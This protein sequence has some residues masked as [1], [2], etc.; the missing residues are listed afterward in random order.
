MA[1]ASSSSSKIDAT[2]AA[3]RV[4]DDKSSP[5]SSP[6]VVPSYE[7]ALDALLGSDGGGG[8]GGLHQSTT[9]E[10]IRAA[11]ARRTHTVRDMRTYM[12]RC[13]LLRTPKSGERDDATTTPHF[14][15]TKVIHVTGT[16]GKGSVACLCERILRQ[17]HGV[18]TGL[19]TS[20]HLIDV[21]E[22]IR[23]NG[24]PVSEHVFADAYWR[25]RTMLERH[26][27]G[28][29]AATGADGAVVEEDDAAPLPVLPGYFRMLTLMAFYIFQNYEF[30][31]DDDYKKTS[32][33][34]GTKQKQ[35]IDVIILEV[36]MGGRFD[37]TNSYCTVGEDRCDADEPQ[38]RQQQQ[39]VACGIT[40]IDYDHCRVLGDT[41]SE[42]AWEKGGIYQV[43]KGAMRPQTPHPRRNA[44]EFAAAV[45]HLDNDDDDSNDNKIDDRVSVGTPCHRSQW[46]YFALDTNDAAVWPVF[47]LCAKLEGENRS[48]V[49]FVGT[50]NARIPTHC[51]IGLQGSH[52]RSNAE[53]AWALCEAV[54]GSEHRVSEESVYQA[55]AEASWPGR[56]QTIAWQDNADDGTPAVNLRLDG[57]HTLQSV[58]AGL[59]WY[60]QVAAAP[61][62]PAE[63]G[64]CRVL[65]FNCS[66]ER[67]PVELLQ[68]LVR[69]KFHAVYFCKADSARPS[70]VAMARAHELLAK[71]GIAALPEKENSE[72][73]SWL[74]TLSIIWRNLDNSSDCLHETVCIENAKI[75][76]E[77]AVAISANVKGV[78][79]AEIF[80]T[81]SL[82]LVGSVLKA[83]EWK[84]DNAEGKLQKSSLS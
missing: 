25:I 80:V 8:S 73:K 45:A 28:H 48:K 68:L 27:A 59:E 66:H 71:A 35:K 22:R 69:A 82:Y 76:L 5:S 70:A 33:S 6:F 20:P 31:Q 54:M 74:E 10:A 42:I 7:A 44:H 79:R 11:A 38:D 17:A 84:E 49:Q 40:L 18:R 29:N 12:R 13:D 14:F 16:K 67:N 53:L 30:P 78:Q 43:N 62:Q 19:F 47:R 37:A 21:R 60:R 36:G 4:H 52:Q 75:A 15:P 72:E 56:C 63:D 46:H 51:P 32:D 65:I 9:P 64:V 23:C 24:S 55:L 26:A 3:E 57:A 81:G 41:L 34:A 58:S 77:R 61:A 83:I 39:T 1:Q 50:R 2:A